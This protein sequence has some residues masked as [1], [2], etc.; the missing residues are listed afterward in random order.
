MCVRV[1]G[2]SPR[3]MGN[4]ASPL[5]RIVLPSKPINVTD[6]GF[7][8]VSNPISCSAPRKMISTELPLSTR[9][10][11]TSILDMMALINQGVLM[12][13]HNPLSI[14]ICKGEENRMFLT[15]YSGLYSHN[16][17]RH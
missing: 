13:E 1:I 17:S 6:C 10:L 15:V 12:G 2:S 14:F 11:L 3:V 5:V 7:M 8:A 9:I 4:N 16:A